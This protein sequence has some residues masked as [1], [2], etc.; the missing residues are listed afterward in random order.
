MSRPFL[1][2]APTRRDAGGL[3]PS[4]ARFLPLRIQESTVARVAQGKKDSTAGY[5]FST[6]WT[7]ARTAR[8]PRPW[9]VCQNHV[10]F[11]KHGAANPKYRGKRRIRRSRPGSTQKKAHRARLSDFMG[12]AGT[13]PWARTRKQPQG[14]QASL[15][16]LAETGGTTED[17]GRAS[18]RSTVDRSF[19]L[20]WSRPC[21]PSSPGGAERGGSGAFFTR[22]A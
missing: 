7:S 4:R 20:A 6:W 10:R 5:H 12:L 9:L 2:T 11:D 3:L 1:R 17:S 14:S 19:P 22:A 18:R 13:G 8:G 16:R 21:E 15:L